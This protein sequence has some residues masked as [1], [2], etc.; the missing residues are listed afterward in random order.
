MNETLPESPGVN[1]IQTLLDGGLGWCTAAA[2]TGLQ[3]PGMW[4]GQGQG[5]LRGVAWCEEACP[6]LDLYL[7]SL[8]SGRV[9]LCQLHGLTGPHSSWD[10]R[11]PG[12]S[13]SAHL[14][15]PLTGNPVTLTWDLPL[16]LMGAWE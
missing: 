2:A 10:W 5:L 4:L 1:E 6:L 15:E 11:D 9:L 13:S 8:S 16:P 7:F 12:P 3:R 14:S